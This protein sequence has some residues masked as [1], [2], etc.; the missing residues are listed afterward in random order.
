MRTKRVREITKPECQSSA[1][2][3]SVELMGVF[4]AFYVLICKKILWFYLFYFIFN[5]KYIILVI[6]VGAV[7]S[8]IILIFEI[9]IKRFSKNF[10]P[11]KTLKTSQ[12]IKPFQFVN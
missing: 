5:I 7:F 2:V 3:Q 4:D 11:K 6:S 1:T 10:Q 8:I 12:K 9:I